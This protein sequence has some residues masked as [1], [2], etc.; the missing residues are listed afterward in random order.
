[1]NTKQRISDSNGCD[2][3]KSVKLKVTTLTTRSILFINIIFFYSVSPPR[4]GG[5]EA[6]Y[7]SGAKRFFY[8]TL[9]K[10]FL[11]LVLVNIMIPQRL[12]R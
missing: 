4:M 9:K 2:L 10:N 3:N 11:L 7:L 5:G 12:E 8:E 6:S 1:M